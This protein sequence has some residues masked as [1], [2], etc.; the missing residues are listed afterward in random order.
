MAAPSPTGSWTWIPAG[1]GPVASRPRG[2]IGRPAVSIGV[3]SSTWTTASA[4]SG[5]G[6]PVAI[7]MAVPRSTAVDG[8]RP[9]RTS[10]MTV[11]VAGA[12]SVA[13]RMSAAR[14]A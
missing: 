3:V 5:T 13:S 1:I 10:P 9:A 2:P 7:R 12:D 6:A 8:A 14:I 4:P 11:N